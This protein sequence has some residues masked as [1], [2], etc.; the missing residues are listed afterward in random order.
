MNNVLITGITG[1]SGLYMLKEMVAHA[2]ELHDYHFTIFVRETTDTTEIDK[3]VE[4]LSIEK[5]VGDKKNADDVDKIMQGGYDTL[6]HLSTIRDSVLLVSTALKYNISRFILVHTTGIYSKYKA[7]GEEYREIDAKVKEMCSKAN[8]SLA[9]LRPTM[10]YGT[11][12]DHNMSV[13]ISLVD[14]Y[15]ICPTVNGAKYELQPVWCGD[16]G[17][18]YYRVLMCPEVTANKDYT[19]SGG[20]VIQL[21]DILKF[22]GAQLGVNSRFI[23][24]P[25]WLAYSGACVIWA[26]TLGKKDLREKVQR[27]VEPRVYNHDAATRDFGY[28][29]LTL[30]EGLIPEIEEY[31]RK[32]TQ[33]ITI[34]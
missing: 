7:A 34:S 21:I 22:I 23:S 6:V 24:V 1:K 15:R 13:F 12:N 3:A 9:I 26:L 11:M 32:K 14:K 27:L 8:A 33:R 17:K 25:Y 4:V 5:F 28:N 31:K 30:R 29:P 2:D 20:E 10:I 16:L 19:L 18:A